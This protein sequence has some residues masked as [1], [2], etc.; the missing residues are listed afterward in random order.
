LEQTGKSWTDKNFIG[1]KR[2]DFRTNKASGYYFESLLKTMRGDPHKIPVNLT[3]K[4]FDVYSF[5]YMN[6]SSYICTFDSP[7]PSWFQVEFA[8][9]RVAVTG[10]RFK[11]HEVL[12]LRSWTLRGSNDPTLDVAAW[13][14]LH[15]VNETKNEGLFNV[16]TCPAGEP[17]KFIR[18]LM[19]GP[20]WNDRTYLAFWHF[21]I[22]G[23]YVID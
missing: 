5:I 13:T 16:Y 17:V 10:Y 9:G 7:L 11:R 8:T 2:M 15:Q 18:I 22:F 1:I 19:E 3:S 20:G 14:V 4:Y 6:P 21:E 23:D 12:K